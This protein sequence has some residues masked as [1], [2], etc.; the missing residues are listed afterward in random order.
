MRVHVTSDVHGAAAELSR[1]AQGCDA[2]VCLGDLICFLDY[3]DPTR[4][5][6]ADLF[7]ADHAAEYIALR[8]ANRFEE[9]RALSARAWSDLGVDGQEGRW[10]VMQAMVRAQYEELFDAMPRPALLTYGNVDL[11]D[12][13]PDFL[14]EGHRVLDGQVVEVEGLRW[15]FVGGGLPSPMRTPFEVPTEVY[16]DKVAALGPVDV[17][18]TH[19]PPALPELTYDVEARRFEIGSSALLD[20]VREHQPRYHLFGHIHQPLASRMRIG[21][22]ECINVGHFQG[23]GVPFVLDLP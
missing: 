15:G 1:A 16:A 21:R 2:F 17:L 5:I 7:G 12:L 4:G 18:F 13:W 10:G 9:A 6:F 22:T 14:A 3:H 11:P 19:I 8:T 20:Y 23:T